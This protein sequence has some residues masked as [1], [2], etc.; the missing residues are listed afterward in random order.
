M[1]LKLFTKQWMGCFL[2]V[3]TIH[4]AHGQVT[5]SGTL[6]DA[7]DNTP[8]IGVNIIIQGT[9]QGTITDFDGNYTIEVPDGNTVLEYSYTG[10]RSQAVTVGTQREISLKMAP[11][12][13]ALEEVVVV[14]YTTRKR[15]ELTGSVSTVDNEVL[16]RT[17]NKDLV[18]SL[19]GRVP[20]LIA[21]DRGG[22]PGS[23][24]DVTLLIRG[25]STLGDNSPLILVDGVPSESFAHLSP[26]DIE[27]LS[28]LKDGA[29]AIYGARAANGVILITT[30]RGQ[31]GKPQ[32]NLTSTYTLSTLSSIPRL[33]NSEQYAIYENEI[34]ERN[35]FVTPYTAEDISNFA[36]GTDPIRYP[37]TDWYDLTFADYSPEWRNTLSISG[38]TERVNYFVSGDH[39]DMVGL[40]ESGDL[41]FT[42]Y[43]LRSNVDI[44]LH[45]SFSV[46]IDLAGRFG[47]R[48]EPGVD[49]GFIYKHIYTN[50]PTEVGVYPNG[51]VAWGGENGAN[52]F[53]MSSSR[54]W[55]YQ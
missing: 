35:G 42:Q 25:K 48:N 26:A 15:G 5:V 17:P 20:G 27:S 31:T 29:A 12:A 10:Y 2:L 50:E 4:F 22:Y 8:L 39:I 54:I 51:L 21:V 11:N 38:G 18:K 7:E 28:V 55:F 49:A 53:I 34:A 6:T 43:Q 9:S 1:R 41:N 33:M 47:D 14:G 36:A 16:E 13:T 52:P 37:S 3:F 32:I 40:Y 46:G 45:E 19:S 24:N 30:K 23:T 44:K